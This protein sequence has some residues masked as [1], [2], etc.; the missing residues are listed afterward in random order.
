LG[1]PSISSLKKSR[2]PES[3]AALRHDRSFHNHALREPT[4]TPVCPYM[5]RGAVS[6]SSSE[7][8]LDT[9]YHWEAER[10][11]WLRTDYITPEA[12]D[13]F[14]AGAPSWTTS[15]TSLFR[16]LPEWERRPIR[17]PFRFWTRPIHLRLCHS[18]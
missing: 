2:S 16:L 10:W 17:P 15:S 9:A 14:Q 1:M 8:S 18:L 12:G 13:V 11:A 7:D 5:S 3:A 6:N 4:P